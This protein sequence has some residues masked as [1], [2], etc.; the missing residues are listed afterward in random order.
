MKPICKT[1]S[2]RSLKSVRKECVCSRCVANCSKLLVE[3]NQQS[4]RCA[5]AELGRARYTIALIEK[6]SPTKATN[7]TAKRAR[8]AQIDSVEV[9]AENDEPFLVRSTFEAL[10]A[11]LTCV[12]NG[13]AKSSQRRQ[14]LRDHLSKTEMRV[15]FIRKPSF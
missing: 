6:A 4:L 5:S 8:A 7:V 15:E 10:C 1:I 13:A 9:A 14:R 11:E 12:R 3:M 2:Q